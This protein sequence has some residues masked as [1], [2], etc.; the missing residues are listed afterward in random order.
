MEAQLL[1]LG[2]ESN[3]DRIHNYRVSM[4]NHELLLLSPIK[5]V[6]NTEISQ[7]SEALMKKH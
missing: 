5:I 3:T 6:N 7:F 1:V 2:H 4:V